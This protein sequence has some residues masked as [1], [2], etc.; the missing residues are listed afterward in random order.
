M[1]M[2]HRVVGIALPPS[3][4]NISPFHQYLSFLLGAGE[5]CIV[6]TFLIDAVMLKNVSGGRCCGCW[7]RCG[8]WLA[9]VAGVGGV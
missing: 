8:L 5:E 4:A 1:F 6:I 7:L 9:T 2:V 3:D